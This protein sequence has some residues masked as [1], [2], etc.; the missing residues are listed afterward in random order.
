MPSSLHISR[1]KETYPVCQPFLEYLAK[2]GRAIDMPISYNDLKRFDNTI[3]LY[4]K[5]KNDSLWVTALYPQYETNLIR[6]TEKNLF[7]LKKWWRPK[8]SRT[9]EH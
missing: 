3:T 4:D 8:C 7:H 2:Y 5:H 6:W 9:L 1:K